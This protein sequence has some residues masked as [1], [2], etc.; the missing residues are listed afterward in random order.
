MPPTPSS[1]TSTARCTR[2][3][4]GPR[5]GGS[6]WWTS[7]RTRWRGWLPHHRTRTSTTSAASG[8]AAR[9]PQST[10]RSPPTVSSTPGPAWG[11]RIGTGVRCRCPTTRGRPCGGWRRIL[12]PGTCGLCRGTGRGVLGTT[13]CVS[14]SPT[15]SPPPT[16]R[17]PAWS[18]APAPPAAAGPRSP[19]SPATTSASTPPSPTPPACSSPTSASPDPWRRARSPSSWR[20]RGWASTIARMWS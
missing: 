4:L 8:I 7:S 3:T 16:R 10:W 1:S 20:W 2:A 19:A 14:A 9:T 15:S 5:T 11:T 12:C 18:G 6:S 17:P 13:G